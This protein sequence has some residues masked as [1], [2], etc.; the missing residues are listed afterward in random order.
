MDAE[1]ATEIARALVGKQLFKPISG[2]KVGDLWIVIAKLGPFEEIRATFE[3]P[4]KLISSLL[5][6]QV[7]SNG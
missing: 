6:Q 7:R 5:Y 3:I 2:R 4:D 1:R